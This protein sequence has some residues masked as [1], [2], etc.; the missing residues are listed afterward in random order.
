MVGYALHYSEGASSVF[1]DHQC[2]TYK[3][4]QHEPPTPVVTFCNPRNPQLSR[5]WQIGERSVKLQILA[6]EDELDSK[7]LST[8]LSK[9]ESIKQQAMADSIQVSKECICMQPS[10]PGDE[11]IRARGCVPPASKVRPCPAQSSLTQMS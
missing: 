3:Y 8:W 10:S 2:R 6:F 1:D 7:L 11:T 4:C 9:T 5:R